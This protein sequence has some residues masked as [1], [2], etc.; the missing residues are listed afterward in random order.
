MLH[1]IFVT[2]FIVSIYIKCIQLYIYSKYLS[3]RVKIYV[4]NYRKV[5]NI[6]IPRG[7]QP[8]RGAGMFNGMKYFEMERGLT[9]KLQSIDRLKL[10]QSS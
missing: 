2:I 8:V 7:R 9:L 5:V 1:A 3:L 10:Y 4:V 6:G